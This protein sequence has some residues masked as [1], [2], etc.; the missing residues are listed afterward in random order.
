[1]KS[2]NNIREFAEAHGISRQVVEHRIKAGWKF[3][4]LDGVKVMYNPKY[5]NKVKT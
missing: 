1:M 2:I 5:F 3:G 4:V